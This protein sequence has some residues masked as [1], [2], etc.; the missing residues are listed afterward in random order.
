MI[1]II[2]DRKERQKKLAPFIFEGEHDEMRCIYTNEE[3]GVKKQKMFNDAQF[4]FFHDSFFK[5][6]ENKHDEKSFDQIKSDFINYCQKNHIKV[7]VFS[8]DFPSRRIDE[9]LGFL[10]V[11]IFYENLNV[12]YE[13]YIKN[14]RELKLLAFGTNY[15]Y[16]EIYRLRHNLFVKILE[17][18]S[19]YVTEPTFI[20]DYCKP[21][22]DI[23][24][25]KASELEE[26]LYDM[27]D[28]NLLTKDYLTSLINK[29]INEYIY[30]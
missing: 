21:I 14:N 4:I 9:N 28:D 6:H 3:L 19:N 30:E 27:I 22:L 7:I 10:P 13:N 23:V 24:S 16:E 29:Y 18:E 5:K 15:K 8:G 12:F 25:T 20:F 17:I 11:D 26:F 2:D 1:Y